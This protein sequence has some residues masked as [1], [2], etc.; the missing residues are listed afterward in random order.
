MGIDTVKIYFNG[1][2]A[3]RQLGKKRAEIRE[4][5]EGITLRF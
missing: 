3:F 1:F 2:G 5:R 4:W